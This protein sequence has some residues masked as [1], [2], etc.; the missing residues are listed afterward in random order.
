M[1]TP[2]KKKLNC[3]GLPIDK[4]DWTTQDWQDLHEAVERV[5]RNIA[6]RHANDD[7]PGRRRESESDGQ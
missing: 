5:K 2:H 6:R 3:D 7:D 1:S 4:N